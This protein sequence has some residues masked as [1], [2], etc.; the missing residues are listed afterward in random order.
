MIRAVN[1]ST[2]KFPIK[3]TTNQIRDITQDATLSL[4][5][6][7]YVANLAFYRPLLHFFPIQPQNSLYPRESRILT[8][9]KTDMNV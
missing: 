8:G 1:H 3:A 4:G 6:E 9:W 2:G 5:L 7:Q